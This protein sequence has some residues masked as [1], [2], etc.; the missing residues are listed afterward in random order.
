MNPSVSVVISTYNGAAFIGETLSSIFAQTHLPDEVLIVDDCSTDQTE[1]VVSSFARESP[2]PIR[3]ERLQ[4]NTGNPSRPLNVGIS[5]AAGEF[6]LTLD[7]DDLMRPHRV[8][9]SLKAMQAFPNS[10][11]AIGRF[12]ILGFE[13]GDVR[14]VWPTSQFSDISSYIDPVAEFSLLDSRVAF[15]ALLMKN[16]AGSTSNFC[17]TK[18]L[19]EK[20]G[21]FDESIKTC[22]DLDFILR[23]VVE[24]PIVI[25]NEVLLDYRWREASLNHTNARKTDM[26]LTKV[27][28]LAAS[29][30]PDWAGEQRLVLEDSAV[31]TAKLALKRGDFPEAITVLNTLWKNGQVGTLLKRKIG[32]PKDGGPVGDAS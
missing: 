11:F 15:A 1:S 10:A 22:S 12:S 23:V 27:R 30:K 18:K 31:H 6:I 3:F 17:F 13:E 14:K 25:I 16:F 20:I 2:I 24:T 7:Q 26:E 8:E 5:N 4:Q 19:W 28:L 29:A 9:A 21:G 32:R